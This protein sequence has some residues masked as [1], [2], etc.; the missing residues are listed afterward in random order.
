MEECGT[1]VALWTMKLCSGCHCRGAAAGVISASV[2][3][4]IQPRRGSGMDW[5][6]ETTLLANL[7]RWNAEGKA[8]CVK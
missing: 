8:R 5:R 2:E 7:K 1:W 3:M 6:E 4:R